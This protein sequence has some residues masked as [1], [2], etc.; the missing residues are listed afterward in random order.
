M[1]VLS[2]HAPDFGGRRMLRLTGRTHSE[3]NVVLSTQQGGSMFDLS[4][5][6]VRIRTGPRLE[7][8][9]EARIRL[10]LPDGSGQITCRCRVIWCKACD[11]AAREHLAGLEFLDLDDDGR[12]RLVR[13]LGRGEPADRPQQRPAGFGPSRFD[14]S[15]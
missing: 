6:G 3:G 8:G 13:A 12:R 10:Q 15:V 1:P 14:L 11:P 7:P 9:S 4:P 2:M 5:S